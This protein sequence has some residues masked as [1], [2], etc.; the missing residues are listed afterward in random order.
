[1]PLTQLL[2]LN[3]AGTEVTKRS[4]STLTNLTHLLICDPDSAI[5][6][7]SILALTNLVALELEGNEAIHAQGFTCLP[8]LQ[9][10]VLGN[11]PG[12]FSSFDSRFIFRCSR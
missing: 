12:V 2:T 11:C 3:I 10:L 4:L 5:P 8:K 6:D 9:S 7:A 1:M